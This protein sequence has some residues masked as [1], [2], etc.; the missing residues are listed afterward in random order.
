MSSFR[1][2]E[3]LIGTEITS[4]PFSTFSSYLISCM[5]HLSQVITNTDI[6]L[7]TNFIV[8][9]IVCS[10]YCAASWVLA[11]KRCHMSVQIITVSANIASTPYK[12]PP[13]QLLTPLPPIS[14]QTTDLSTLSII[15]CPFQNVIKL[16][17]YSVQK[18]FQTGLFNLVI[19][20]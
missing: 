12:S 19:S 9:T 5:I 18:L 8:G 17:I 2:T 4:N 14:C 16:E 11:H 20:T 10:L 1:F 3:K 13:L 6:L 15:F 7:L